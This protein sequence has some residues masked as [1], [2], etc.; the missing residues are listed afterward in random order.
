MPLFWAQ[1]T[2]LKVR[3]LTL[4][5]VNFSFK[6]QLTFSAFMIGATAVEVTLE[7]VLI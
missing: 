5:V 3:Q 7:L 6:S 2:A 1:L 4:Q